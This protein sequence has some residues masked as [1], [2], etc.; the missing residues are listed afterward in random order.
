MAIRPRDKRALQLGAMALTLWVVLRFV[1]FPAWDRWQQERAELP[2]RETALVKY[3]QALAGFSADQRTAQALQD[4]LRQTESGL[5]ES[6]TAA[7]AAAEFQDWVRQATAR[8]D[9]ALQSSQFLAVRP[10]PEGYAQVPLGL[11]FQCRLDQLVNFLAELRTGARLVAV[12]RLQIQSTGNPAERT[13]TVS[14]T[15]AGVIRSQAA[16]QNPSPERTEVP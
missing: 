6:T 13:I 8:H 15:V 4:R 16:P 11:Q 3:R 10:Q 9:I 14:M 7:L 2:L 5:L 1:V 12:P